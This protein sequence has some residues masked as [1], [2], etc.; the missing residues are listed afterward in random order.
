MLVN[1]AT[2]MVDQGTAG[3]ADVDLAMRK[4]MNYPRGP[5]EWAALL[6]ASLLPTVLDQLWTTTRD[7]RFARAAGL[8][9]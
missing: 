2:D 4:G 3:A 1:E 8:R 7:A 9:A 5:L 6:P